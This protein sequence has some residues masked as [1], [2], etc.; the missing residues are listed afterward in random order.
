M[1]LKVAVC[2]SVAAVILA[3]PT[4]S[5][6]EAPNLPNTVV[7]AAP[8][9]GTGSGTAG[10]GDQGIVA[11]A[12]S[13]QHGGGG[14]SGG[15]YSGGG[16]TF[17]Q[18]PLPTLPYIGGFFINTHAVY[19]C[20][21]SQTAYVVRAPDGTNLGV[22]CVPNPTP[23]TPGAGNPVLVLAQEASGRQP[24]P[25]LGVDANPSNGLAGVAAW[26]WLGQGV[27]AIPP[28][29]ATSGPITVT[30]RATL[31]DVVW[32][33]GDGSPVFDSGPSA[34]RP[35]PQPS[36]ITHVYQTDSYGLPGGYTV[37]ASLS[38]TVAFSV[39]GGPWTAFGSKVRA[40]SASYTVGQAQP[41]AVPAR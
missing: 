5:L 8:S 3:L 26:F 25:G 21:P 12:A 27:T 1:R 10:Y 34:G 18:I 29:S 23:G 17:T 24:W 38:F 15:T 37:T 28:A 11:T 6:A 39:N 40:Y 41:E 32:D 19:P 30:V 33:F 35:Y 2:L 31:T 7:V 16:Y 20:P 22:I 36:D 4:T 9:A 14:G 13:E